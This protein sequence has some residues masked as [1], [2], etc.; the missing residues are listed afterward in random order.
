MTGRYQQVWL[1]NVDL[2]SVHPS[3]LLQHIQGTLSQRAFRIPAGGIDARL[4]VGVAVG[5]CLMGQQAQV[6]VLHRVDILRDCQ[7]DHGIAPSN[8]A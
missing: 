5:G 2:A 6:A 4:P 3:I 7:T 1:N 8:R